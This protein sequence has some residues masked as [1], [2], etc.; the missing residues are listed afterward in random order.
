V[1]QLE[2]D[3]GLA[4]FA[5]DVAADLQ[6]ADPQRQVTFVIAPGV[7]ADGDELLL[8]IVLTN[9][10]DNA[11]KF[12][13]QHPSPR[14]EFGS[15]EDGGRPAYYVRDNGAGF[16]M[17]YAHK[18]FE[19]FQRLHS[20]QEFEGSG[21]GLATV[22]RAILRHGGRVWAVGDPGQGATFHFQLGAL[23]TS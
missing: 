16:D 10:L 4:S 19:V 14:I 21:I 8:R 3:A 17:R 2:G 5:G 9:L 18:L 15:A 7:V 6:R 11:W 20:P 1:E 22:E 12:T 13:R 23:N